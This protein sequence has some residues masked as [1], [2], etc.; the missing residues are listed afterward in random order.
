M[1][2]VLLLAVLIVSI[3]E[4]TMERDRMYLF[5]TTVASVALIY[6]LFHQRHRIRAATGLNEH[7][8][9]ERNKL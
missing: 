6:G 2:R 3:V 9:A 7:P 1:K 4:F 8:K 5:L